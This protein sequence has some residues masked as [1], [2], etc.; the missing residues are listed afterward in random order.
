MTAAPGFS[1][2]GRD[3]LH[4]ALCD[5]T[6]CKISPLGFQTD[7][8]QDSQTQA[9]T[10]EMVKQWSQES[11]PEDAVVDTALENCLAECTSNIILHMPQSLSTREKKDKN[12][13]ATQVALAQP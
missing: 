2:L 1:L 6:D 12:E 8:T 9:E 13:E 4:W 5:K 7:S 10:A 3:G 11:S